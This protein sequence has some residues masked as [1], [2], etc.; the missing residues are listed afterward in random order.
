M[1]G[2]L[3]T[4]VEQVS[5]TKILTLIRRMFPKETRG[6]G[7]VLQPLGELG[8]WELP[9]RKERNSLG[10]PLHDDAPVVG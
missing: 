1:N 5:P 8:L 7:R 2:V 4:E 3:R 6:W 10:Q 9:P